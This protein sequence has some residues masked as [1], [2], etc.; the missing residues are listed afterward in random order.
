MQLKSKPSFLSLDNQKDTGRKQWLSEAK[1][2]CTIGTQQ[3]AQAPKTSC[4]FYAMNIVH[5]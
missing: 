4:L 5:Q 2:N 3:I 1:L